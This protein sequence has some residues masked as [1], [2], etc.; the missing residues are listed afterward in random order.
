[1]GTRPNHILK[2]IFP[3]KISAF[4]ALLILIAAVGLLVGCD[5]YEFRGASGDSSFSDISEIDFTPNI[6]GDVSIDIPLG[7]SGDIQVDAP[8]DIP[9]VE[10]SYEEIFYKCNKISP[11][12]LPPCVPPRPPMAALT[13]DDGPSAY[14]DGILDLLETYGGRSTF[15][16]SVPRMLGRQSTVIRAFEAG[17]E[18]A[19]HT[20]N[21]PNLATLT[22]AQIRHE[23]L[24]ASEAIVSV[25]GVSPPMY[26]PPFG[27]TNER[28]VQISYELGYTIV[29]WTVDPIDWRYRN[30]D[31]IYEYIMRNVYDGAIILVH[32]TRP[33]TA[34]AMRR[35]IP[36]LVEEGFRLV[37]V[38]E[39]LYYFYGSLE[40]GQV[41]GSY[42]IL[43]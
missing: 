4:F 26:R 13:F 21:H 42:T 38:S 14:T 15:F 25:T 17:H 6:P 3:E 22:D 30:A 36:R 9:C 24:A 23:I 8:L 27:M 1:M 34:E 12:C 7:V 5:E 33:T 16:V 41:H 2:K 35:V 43:D 11:P 37:T 18:I 10:I 29:K 32:D 40:P 28:V 39:L 19:N 20:L 31:I